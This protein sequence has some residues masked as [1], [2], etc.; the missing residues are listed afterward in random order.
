MCEGLVLDIHDNR[1][2]SKK[3]MVKKLVRGS[4]SLPI[5]HIFKIIL[6]FFSADGFALS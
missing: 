6:I 4:S 3:E 2:C 5:S 1:Q